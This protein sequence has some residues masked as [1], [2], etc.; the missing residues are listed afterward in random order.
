MIEDALVRRERDHLVHVLERDED[1]AATGTPGA[2]ARLIPLRAQHPIQR[3]GQ[4]IG[5]HED[6]LDD[7]AVPSAQQRLIQHLDR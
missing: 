6:R 2:E 1:H 5:L 4:I 7:D 3:A